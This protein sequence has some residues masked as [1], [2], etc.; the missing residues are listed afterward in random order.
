MSKKFL[1]A[2]WGGLY[3]LCAVL[4]FLPALPLGFRILAAVLFFLPPVLLIRTGERQVLAL[5]RNLS[6]I[7]LVLTTALI[8]ANFLTVGASV[9]LGNVFYV[10]L[11]II[12]SPMIC[13]EI[14]VL[15]LFGWACLLFAA[16]SGLRSK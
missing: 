4:G 13:G 9:Q 14:W 6:A 8:I 10:L 11:V 1:F 2:L 16:I 3:I 5:I 7:W 15:S 12:S